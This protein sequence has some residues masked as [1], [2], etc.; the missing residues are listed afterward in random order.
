MSRILSL[1][2]RGNLVSCVNVTI[3]DHFQ[4][5]VQKKSIL[6]TWQLIVMCIQ[7]QLLYLCYLTCASSSVYKSSAGSRSVFLRSVLGIHRWE[8]KG[9]VV[10]AQQQIHVSP[11]VLDIYRW[12]KTEGVGGGWLWK[13]F[14]FFRTVWTYIGEWKQRR[15]GSKLIHVSQ[16]VLDIKTGQWKQRWG[17]FEIDLEDA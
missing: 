11:S 9:R 12:M 17:G 5:S 14:M 4:E 10:V 6:L 2:K 15:G 8:N 7:L 13:R 1:T 16:S 3:N